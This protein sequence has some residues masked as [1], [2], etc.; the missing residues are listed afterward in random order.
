MAQDPAYMFNFTPR[1]TDQ[2]WIR[3]PFF[4]AIEICN[5]NPGMHLV[6]GSGPRD[7]AVLPTPMVQACRLEAQQ[8]GGV[9]LLHGPKNWDDGPVLMYSIYPV[10]H[11]F[12]HTSGSFSVLHYPRGVEA[13]DFNNVL[14]RYGRPLQRLEYPT[15][16]YR[17][18]QYARS[19]PLAIPGSLPLA[20]P[21]QTS[22]LPHQST[23]TKN[24][25]SEQ[26]GNSSK[27][28][29]PSHG[30][31]SQSTPPSLWSEDTPH[32]RYVEARL[33]SLELDKEA[34]DLK[35]SLSGG[36]APRRSRCNTRQMP[37]GRKKPKRQVAQ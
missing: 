22:N 33:E 20:P 5:K 11:H 9:L 16:S 35:A 7:T 1:P 25:E 13:F 36:S 31:K 8:L 14:N 30:R 37:C 23:D 10:P 17:S 32:L 15:R 21:V 4:N 6:Y 24:R 18:E 34:E 3:S 19:R 29:H 2:L 12:H 26:V 27:S 28:E